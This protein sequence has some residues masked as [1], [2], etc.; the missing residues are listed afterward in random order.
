[1]AF[2]MDAYCVYILYSDSLDKFY[3]GSTHDLALRIHIHN[4][5]HEGRKFTAKGIPW[6][7]K[8]RID[9]IDKRH[10]VLIESKIKSI[11]SRKF[12]E[13]LIV[14]EDFRIQFERSLNT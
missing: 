6:M 9:C 11:K 7:L 5:P 2:F 12:I 3:I 4:N 14:D 13:R 8:L 1:M 10:A